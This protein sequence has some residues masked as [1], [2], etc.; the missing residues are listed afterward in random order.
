MKR[1]ERE[2]KFEDENNRH[3]KRE[4]SV[5]EAVLLVVVVLRSLIVCLKER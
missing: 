3:T 5:R 2:K 4:Q 1:G